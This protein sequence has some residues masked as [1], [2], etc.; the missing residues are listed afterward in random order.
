MKFIG[1]GQIPKSSHYLTYICASGGEDESDFVLGNV[2]QMLDLCAIAGRVS[3][4]AATTVI[5]LS[6]GQR[7]KSNHPELRSLEEALAERK[8]LLGFVAKAVGEKTLLDLNRTVN[9]LKSGAA[10]LRLAAKMYDD[11]IAVFETAPEGEV[12]LR[13][14]CID[15][16]VCMGSV[17]SESAALLNGMIEQYGLTTNIVNIKLKFSND[18]GPKLL[19][20]KVNYVLRTGKLLEK[21]K[22]ELKKIIN[23]GYN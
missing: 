22:T 5:S 8:E 7:E 20:T 1:R 17:Y 23:Q 14:N 15:N 4:Q 19:R 6:E 13:D 9:L 16:L 10:G 11:L 18:V 3:E 2:V 12:A 21:T